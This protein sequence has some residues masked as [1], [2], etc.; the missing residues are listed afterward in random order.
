MPVK[1]VPDIKQQYVVNFREIYANS[2]NCAFAYGWWM[3][4][5]ELIDVQEGVT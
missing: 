2:I 5:L 3:G 4:I 1:W